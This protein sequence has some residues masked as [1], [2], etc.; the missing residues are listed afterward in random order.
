MFPFP[1]PEIAG[2]DAERLIKLLG[3]AQKRTYWTQAR[4]EALVRKVIEVLQDWFEAME[5]GAAN[6]RH[7]SIDC[8]V[9]DEQANRLIDVIDGFFENEVTKY[10]EYWANRKQVDGLPEFSRL[11]PQARKALAEDLRRVLQKSE[12]S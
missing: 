8:T 12:M 10:P 11:A 6:H 9:T 1:G 3:E 2:E 4:W 5:R 7:S